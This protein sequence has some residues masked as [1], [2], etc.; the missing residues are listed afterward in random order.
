[1]Q[2]NG[3]L[4][5]VDS[6]CLHTGAFWQALSPSMRVRS[7]QQTSTPGPHPLEPEC[8]PPLPS[9]SPQFLL[10]LVVHSFGYIIFILTHISQLFASVPFLAFPVLIICL[11]LLPD[12]SGGIKIYRKYLN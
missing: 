9:D 7:I 3:R 8:F 12:N 11:S 2:K 4:T 6:L 5:V 1:M 10:L